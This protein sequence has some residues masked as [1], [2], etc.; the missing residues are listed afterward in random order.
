MLKINPINFKGLYVDSN[1]IT[2]IS[3]PN[4]NKLAESEYDIR[5]ILTEHPDIDMF[6]SGNGYGD[7]NL[8]VKRKNKLD[9]LACEEILEKVPDFDLNLIDCAKA[10]ERA[11]DSKNFIPKKEPALCVSANLDNMPEANIV[12][13]FNATVEKFKAL[14]PN[15]E[16]LN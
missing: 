8:V 7:M 14:Y 12:K 2:A 15:K 3:V 10:M 4:R 6:V 11:A 5:E 13:L 9:Y 1:T 16:P